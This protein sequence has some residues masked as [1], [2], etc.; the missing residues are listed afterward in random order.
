MIPSFLKLSANQ[1]PERF[2]RG[3]ARIAAFRHS[4]QVIDVEE[5][6]LHVPEDWVASTTPL[7]GEV[8]LGLSK[9]SDTEY[10]RTVIE[11]DP[12]SWLGPRHLRHFGADTGLLVKLLDAGERLP[13]HFHPDRAF[14]SAHLGLAH[15][16]TEAWIALAPAE[17]AV[18]FTRDV[19]AQEIRTWVETQDTAAMLRAM[20]RLEMAEGDAIL[21]PAGLPHA[22]GQGAFVIELQEPTDLS[23]LAEWE[24]FTIDGQVDGHLRLGFD[25][26]LGALD[27]RG[28]SSA[29][30]ARLKGATAATSGALLPDAAEFFRAD[31]FHGDK[32]STGDSWD[33]GLAIVVVTAGTGCLHTANGNSVSL[34]AGETVLVPFA[35][36]TCRL[37][38]G[39]EA[40]VCRPPLP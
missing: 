39:L 27:R 40:V 35:A 29:E 23:I 10:L 13:V 20:H 21:V 28:W 24:G 34:R 26:A 17:V 1:P 9:V 2:Y 4:G 8:T 32:G 30:V 19:S 22:I 31:R 7:F 38:G 5:D 15:G 16:K 11:S 37:S 25:V 14:S 6:L 36:G 33:A 18:A 3:G 12:E